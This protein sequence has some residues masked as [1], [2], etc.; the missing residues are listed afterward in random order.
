MIKIK[1]TKKSVMQEAL[2]IDQ[3]GLPDIMVTLIREDLTSR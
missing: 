1:I 2:K 3:M